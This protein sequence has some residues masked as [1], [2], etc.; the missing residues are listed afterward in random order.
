MNRIALG[1]RRM[2]ERFRHPLMQV[3]SDVYPTDTPRSR[4]WDEAENSP[5]NRVNNTVPDDNWIHITDGVDGFTL[6]DGSSTVTGARG[7][8]S[9]VVNNAIDRLGPEGGIVNLNE[10][11]ISIE[12]EPIRMGF[13]ISDN[14]RGPIEILFSEGLWD[15]DITEEGKVILTR[16]VNEE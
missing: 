16:T 13:S 2:W 7:V 4:Q 9:S 8:S 3:S 1:A 15:I 6:D 12:N 14:Q 5:A 10:G 11:L